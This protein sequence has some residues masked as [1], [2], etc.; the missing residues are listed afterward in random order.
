M[1]AIE[2]LQNRPKRHRNGG[3]I[4]IGD[5]HVSHDS[6]CDRGTDVLG[7]S[8][9]FASSLLDS[10]LLGSI[11]VESSLITSY[12]DDC[13]LDHVQALGVKLVEVVAEH[14]ELVG[15]WSLYGNARIHE[16]AW[17][18]APRFRRIQG[19][20]IDIGLTECVTKHGKKHA[21]MA[22]WCKPVT[23]WLRAGPRLGLKHRWTDEQIETARV[24][25]QDL[26]DN[27]ID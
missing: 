11:V 23:A 20:G 1:L 12:A 16:G 10:T 26:L 21:L 14:C 19:N 2:S 5:P 22:C 4:L 13:I 15:A 9:V 6:Y 24:F 18:R 8:S 7:G 17:R 27:P 3:G 25:Y